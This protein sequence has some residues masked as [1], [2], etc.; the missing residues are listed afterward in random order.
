MSIDAVA[1]VRIPA[2]ALESGGV[3]R[4]RLNPLIDAT[5]VYTGAP[6]GAEPDEHGI[7]LR[8]LLG[9]ALDL[10]DDPR[11]ILIIPDVAEVQSTRYQAAVDEVGEAG[12]WAPVLGED[13]V[14]ARLTA[15]PAGSLEQLIGAALTAMGGELRGEIQ[16]AMAS[17]D[18]ARMADLQHR[19]AAAFGGEE[20]MTAL[21]VR[22]QDA[23]ARS[24][25][26]GDEAPDDLADDQVDDAGDPSATP[27]DDDGEPTR[28]DRS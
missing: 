1:L 28:G 20:A 23:L 5:L 6:F 4:S 12:V 21:A 14:P 19:M 8:H 9:D 22:L 18:T 16:R 11:G 27:A 25:G 2:A 15:A 13:A 26:G 24:T 10:H 17:G 3:P 7:A